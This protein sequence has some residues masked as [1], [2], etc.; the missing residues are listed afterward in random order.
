LLKE[1]KKKGSE[2]APC[3]NSWPEQAACSESAA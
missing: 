2:F 1:K 3:V